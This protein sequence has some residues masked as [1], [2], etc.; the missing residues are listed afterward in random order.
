M[1][2][3]ALEKLGTTI[4]HDIVKECDTEAVYSQD[5]EFWC[6]VVGINPVLFRKEFRRQIRSKMKELEELRKEKK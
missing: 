1:D 2:D 3:N 5:A 4:L 6:D